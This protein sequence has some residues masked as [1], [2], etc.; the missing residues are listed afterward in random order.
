MRNTSV[1]PLLDQ[2]EK[3]IEENPRS[4]I[5]DFANWLLAGKRFGK[6]AKSVAFSNNNKKTSSSP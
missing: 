2:W 1:I 4:D 5:Y 6:R 3:F